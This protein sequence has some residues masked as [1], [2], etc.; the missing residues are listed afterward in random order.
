MNASVIIAA[1]L[2]I[3]A[4]VMAFR[5][6]GCRFDTSGIPGPGGT[7]TPGG[8]GTGTTPHP[9]ETTPFTMGGG[10]Y[11]WPIPDWCN[12]IDLFLLGAGGGGAAGVALANGDGGLG[13]QWN[14]VT[15]DRSS[16]LPET[17]KTITITIGAGGKCGAGEKG[18]AGGK[19]GA[20]GTDGGPT[21]AAAAAMPT[22]TALGGGAGANSG[23]S[24]G[25][26][27]SPASTTDSNTGETFPAGG[28]QTTLGGPGNPFGGGGGGGL[29]IE[30]SGGDGADGAAWV[31]A[32]QN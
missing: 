24:T 21:T 1:P 13:G 32:R 4:I 10:T 26:G 15:I 9:P 3:A 27:P 30:G 11:P 17:T 18:G 29:I 25:K 28:D 31:V 14:T 20:P 5:F 6:V 12:F 22:Q 23:S 8:P 16:D 2:L 7:G 19:G